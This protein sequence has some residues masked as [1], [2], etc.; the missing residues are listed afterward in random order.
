MARFSPEKIEK[1]IRWH[2][3]GCPQFAVTYLAQRVVDRD[4]Q[5]LSPGAAVGIM[6]QSVLLHEM[7]DDDQLL[8]VG[9][10]RDDARRRV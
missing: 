2:H 4:W 10:E 5:G 6:L 7:K 1:H 8:L 3:P 9:V